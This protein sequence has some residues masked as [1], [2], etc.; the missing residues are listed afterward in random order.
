MKSLLFLGTGSVLHATGERNLGTLG[1]LIHRMPWVAWLTLVGA[2]A[3]AGLP[4]LNGFVSEWLLLQA[5]LFALRGAAAVRQHAAAARCGARRA[6]GGARRLCH[7]EVLRRDLPRP[8][9]RGRRSTARTTRACSSASGS[10]WL[11][12]GLRRARPAADAGHRRYSRSCPSSSG[13]VDAPARRRAW[14][15]LVPVAERQAAYAPAGVPAGH[16]GRDRAHRCA[17]AASS[18]TA[19]SRRARPGTVVSRGSMRACRTP[20]KASASRSATSFSRSSRC[21]A[22]CRRRSIA[23]RDYRVVI[24]DRIWQRLLRAA[25]ALRAAVARRCRVAAAGPHRDLPALQLRHARSCC[26]RWCYDA[27]SAVAHAVARG[28]RRARRRAAV[29]RLDQSVPRVAAEQVGAEHLAALSRHPQAL[30]QGRGDRRERLA[31]VS[32]RAV[33]RVR[34]HGVSPRRS[35]PRWARACRSRRAADAIALVGLLATAR[36]FLSLAAMDVGTAFGTLGARREMMV[37]FLA[38]PALLMV[39]FVASLISATHRAAGDL[40]ESRDADAR[41]VSEPRVHGRRVPAGAARRERAHPGRQSGDAPRAHDDSRGH[42]A[43]VLGAA[44]GAHGMGRRAQALQLRV[45]RL[46]AV[47]AVGR[48]DRRAQAPVALLASIPLLAVKL[49][50]AGAGSPSSRRFRPSC[51]CFARRSFSRPRSCSPCWACSCTCCWE[52]DA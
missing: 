41:A 40:R 29:R 9:A 51:A 13:I 44:S 45:H 5:F 47:R 2:L 15:L 4:P 26:W 33:R 17:G 35:F 50:A 23:R 12:L 48:R 20:R 49:A 39:I 37:G 34:R 28:A 38:E 46:R 24:G 8:A 6:R 43:R 21:S 16:R 36:V 14:W 1:G 7:G 22:S 32:R 27:R 52:P 10:L 18:I 19:A 11:A 3:I 42:A 25:R 31:A 30:S